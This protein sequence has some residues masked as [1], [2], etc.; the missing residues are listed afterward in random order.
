[1]AKFIIRVT[2]TSKGIIEV[3]ADSRRSAKEIA[4][5]IW[6]QNGTDWEDG[7]TSFHIIAPHTYEPN[8]DYK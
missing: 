7:E 6:Y 8:F 2:E 4:Q 3:E 5:A 1:M